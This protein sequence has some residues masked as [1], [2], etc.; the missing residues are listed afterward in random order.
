MDSSEAKTL[1]DTF[2][3]F[4]ERITKIYTKIT[5][6]AN[7]GRYSLELNLLQDEVDKLI[8]NDFKIRAVKH[9]HK[10]KIIWK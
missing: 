7:E 1:A 10:Y 8:D 3:S 9:K 5:N 2:N 4:N 6:A